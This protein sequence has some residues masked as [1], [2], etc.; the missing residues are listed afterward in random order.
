MS[1]NCPLDFVLN[2]RNFIH[3]CALMLLK[4]CCVLCITYHVNAS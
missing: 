1:V 4:E 2:A 3:L